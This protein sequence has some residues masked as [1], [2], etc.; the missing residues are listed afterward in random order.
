MLDFKT[1]LDMQPS[2][3][4]VSAYDPEAITLSPFAFLLNLSGLPRSNALEIIPGRILR[5]GNKEEIKF[6][7]EWIKSQFGERF[8]GDLWENRW[9]K[10][11]SGKYVKQ[12]AKEWR[13]Y[14]I[15]FS[16]DNKELEHLETA[17]TIS[18]CGL[19]IG[20]TLSQATLDKKVYPVCLYSPPRL[21]QSLSA[22]SR[23]TS[24]PHGFANTLTKKDA[25]QV[26][27]IYRKL[28]AHDH[29]I[30]DLH[31]TFKLVFELKDLPLFSPL[32]ILGYFA[33]LDSILTHPPAPDDR[34]D[35]INRQLKQK[36]ALLNKRWQPPLDYANFQV[37]KNSKKSPHETIWSAMYSYRSAIA[38][39]KVPNFK[40][41]FPVLGSEKNANVLIRD[42]VKKTICQALIEP[43]LLADLHNC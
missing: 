23:A 35:S 24:P 1:L 10:S 7:K 43:Q 2:R 8:G 36:L 25:E 18:S 22:L 29:S 3:K 26:S 39:G 32:Q 12:P 30:F 21:F 17:L 14:I 31:K 4:V 20:F 37:Q 13:Y 40:S 38:H 42:T 33:I 28:E 41:D 16:G 19:E 5:R 27:M 15:E 9:P 34:Y 11:G 6:I